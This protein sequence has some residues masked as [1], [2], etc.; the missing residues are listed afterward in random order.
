[1]NNTIKQIPRNQNIVV[2]KE[3]I[4]YVINRTFRN[5]RMFFIRK[6]LQNRDITLLSNNCNGAMMLH[7]LGLPFNS[8]F[9]NL[10]LIPSDFI[11]YV[12]NIDYYK[13]LDLKFTKS[14]KYS[15]PVGKLG[16]LT[17]YF[18]H[19]H[20][21][22][23]AKEKWMKRT[24]RMKKDNLF[25]LM[26]ERGT[27]TYQ[28]LLDFDRLPFQHKIVLTHKHYPEIKSSYYIKGFEKEDELGI[29]S[30]YVKNQL[31]GKRY[32]DQ[33]DFINWFNNQV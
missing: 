19:Y 6:R 15:Y 5:A 7:D 30:D 28:D 23:E 33:F 29:L 16:D 10:W 17:I 25:L 24:S 8:P 22:S 13:K 9:V 26:T 21:E 14:H 11:K 4:F 20:S 2:N 31:L 32:Y 12:S 18:Q 1:M 3:L 27:C